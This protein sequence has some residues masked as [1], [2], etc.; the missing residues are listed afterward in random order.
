MNYAELKDAAVAY[1]D[2]YDAEVN[3]N[4]DLY[5]LLTEARVNRL[6]KTRKQSAR[7]YIN[8]S[9]DREYYSLPPDW[10][11]MRNVEVNVP[12]SVTSGYSTTV[13]HFAD[14]ITFDRVKQGNITG[15]G[16]YFLIIANQLRIFPIPEVG[17]SIEMVY[18]QKVPNLTA[19]TIELPNAESNWLSEDHPDI[20]LAGMTAEI[21]LFAK[22][23]DAATGW[24]ERLTSAVSE[25][26]SVDWQERWS[27]DPLQ[28]RV[29]Q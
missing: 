21:S 15:Q 1:A 19:A 20:Y 7:A 28:I 25:L 29:S 27:G 17:S 3:D 9:D 22:D 10:A 18:Y 24:Y 8:V 26:D 16:Y 5:I 14:P 11:G 13:A 12:N 23:Y 2:R 4:L 6:L